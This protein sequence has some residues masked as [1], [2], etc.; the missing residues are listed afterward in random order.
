MTEGELGMLR[1]FNELMLRSL[2]IGIAVI[3]R[4]YRILTINAAARRLL[5]I[6][7]PGPDLDFLH[8][9]RGLPYNSV[10]NAIDSVFRQQSTAVLPDIE[11]DPAVGGTG[12]YISFTISTLD[13]ESA[14]PELVMICISDVSDVIET[15]RSLETIQSEQRQLLQELQITN[16]RLGDA[17]KDLQDTNEELQ[18]SNEELMLAQ[19]ELQATNEEFEATN[20][21]LQATNEELETSN[22]ELQATNEELETTNEELQ[23]RSTDLQELARDL[24][25]ER[26][27]LNEMVSLAPFGILILRGPAYL[28]EA[29]NP[30][31]ASILRGHDGQGLPVEDALRHDVPE[32]IKL[33]HRAGKEDR[34][35]VAKSV[36]TT[37]QLESGEQEECLFNY[38][39]VPIHDNEG[40]V[41]GVVVYA[42][43]VTERIAAEEIERRERLRLLIEN[44][45]G[46]S[47]GLF[48]AETGQLL[49][50]NRLYLDIVESAY[51][52]PRDS[53]VGRTWQELMAPAFGKKEAAR[54]FREAVE[55]GRTYRWPDMQIKAEGDDQ[56]TVWTASL[57]PIPGDEGGNVRYLV[58]G[59]AEVTEQAQARAELER[60]DRMKDLFLSSASHELRTPMTPLVAYSELLERAVGKHEGEA[61]WDSKI[62]EHVGHVRRQVLQMRRLI[63]DLFDVA[64]LQSG[65]FT[66]DRQPIDIRHVARQAA[67]DAQ[68]I[69]E[70]R[71]I[72]IDLG[73]ADGGVTVSGDEG[74]LSQV[75]LNLLSNAIKYSD[76]HQPIDLVVRRDGAGSQ[77]SAVVQVRDYGQGID[78]EDISAIFDRFFQAEG[79]TAARHDGLGLGLWIAR[80]IVEQHGGTIEVDSTPGEGT[81]FTL[82]LP[83]AEKKSR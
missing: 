66:L 51:G 25:R 65:K 3:D 36:S 68:L 30:S 21:E 83:L 1:R 18:A 29:F 52:V 60:I 80:A 59:A 76:D 4:H 8:S 42:E 62:T 34:V 61:A 33:I 28:I 32:L 74:R 37:V 53:A 67:E 40:L 7:E 19:E 50:A 54:I 24:A 38:T 9:V 81:T 35:R 58:S 79:A 49:T 13:S 63:N 5:G 11:L 16:R 20:E 14:R 45:E 73:E 26:A 47:L 10:R 77:G 82:K 43:D 70:D 64:R 72:R 27:Q 6:H 56:V 75:L 22:E 31:F 41:H 2:P 23:A 12:R 17:N 57:V 71:E 44:V 46:V 39:V 55:E 78:P 48:D 69:T 15:R